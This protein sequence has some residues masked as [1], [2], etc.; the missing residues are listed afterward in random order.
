LI[1]NGSRLGKLD[2]AEVVRSCAWVRVSID[3]AYKERYRRTHQP[4]G[5][6][7]Q[8]VHDGIAALLVE[9]GSNVVPSVGASFIIDSCDEEVAAEV[10]EFCRQMAGLGVDY[11]QV[12]PEN[13]N[14]GPGVHEFMRELRERLTDVLTGSPMFVIMNDPHQGNTNSAYCWYSHMGTVVG[15]DGSVYVCC[16]TYGQDQFRLGKIDQDRSFDH[17]WQSPERRKLVDAID[18]GTCRSCGHSS[19]NLIMERIYQAGPA[20][21]ATITSDLA[22]AEADPSRPGAVLPDEY[23]WL[24]AGLDQYRLL[25]T[26]GYNPILDFPAY[27]PTLF[28]RGAHG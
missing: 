28:I 26:A 16:Y 6:S 23:S 10:F 14:R 25:L 22:S 18:P 17:V 9:R 19:A 27:R 15:A 21:W 11:I 1:T 3:A 2:L 7:L 12:K 24:Q 13:E 4:R 8:D 5:H 20:L